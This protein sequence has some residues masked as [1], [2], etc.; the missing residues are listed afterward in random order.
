M[1]HEI[2]DAETRRSDVDR[3]REWLKSQLE[4]E[5]ILLALRDSGDRSARHRPPGR[6]AAAA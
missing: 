1:N 6:E 2:S 3:A 5:E 4:W